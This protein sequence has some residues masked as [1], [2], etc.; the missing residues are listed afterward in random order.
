MLR[1]MDTPNQNMNRKFKPAFFGRRYIVGA[2]RVSS[3][4]ELSESC[5]GLNL[6]V[7][8][9]LVVQRSARRRRRRPKPILSFI[10]FG[11]VR[12]VWLDVPGRQSSRIR[13]E[14]RLCLL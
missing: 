9:S 13:R 3:A 6:T 12:G 11:L 14:T 4:T 8:Q 2:P 1:S 5:G 7:I 10:F